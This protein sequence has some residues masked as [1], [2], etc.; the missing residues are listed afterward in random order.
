LEIVPTFLG[1][2]VV[3]PE[4][5]ERREAY[6][7]IVEATQSEA[8][9]R[10]L[11]E[12]ADVFCERE[13]FTL[14]ESRRLLGHAKTL[15]L[16]LKLHAEQFGA[17]GAAALGLELGATSVDHLDCVSKGDIRLLGQS[18]KPP[19]AVLL[20]GVSFHLGLERHAPGRELVD[21]GAPVAIATDFNPGSSFTP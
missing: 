6:L 11:A 16:G 14:D 4:H 21:A 9:Q 5:R 17:S 7:E 12:F 10:G 13:A 1:A 18:A 19:V 20:P 2:H 3:P 8:R 15:G